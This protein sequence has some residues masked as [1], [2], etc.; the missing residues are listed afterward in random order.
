MTATTELRRWWDSLL[1]EPQ[2][3]EPGQKLAAW[4][5]TIAVAVT[6]L[7]ARSK[8]AW[9]W[10]EGLF[11]SALRHYDVRA[12]HPHPPGFPLFIATGKLFTFLGLSEFHA[13]Q[14]ISLLAS[15]AIVPA[16]LMLGRE[17]RAGF[18]PTLIAGVFLAFFPNVWFF[19]GTAFS[20]VPS[21]TIVIVA[22][23]LLLRGCRSD[24]A[25]YGGAIMLGIAAGYRPQNLLIGFAPSMVVVIRAL[26]RRWLQVVI[27]AA[28]GAAIIAVSYGLAAH[29]SG[30]WTSYS[31]VLHA[32]QRYIATVDSYQSPD[33]PPLS[34]MFDKF[35]IRPYRLPAANVFV[36]LL[37]T[38]GAVVA[39]VRVRIPA[40]LML[41]SF[42][43][44]C[45]VAWLV[46]DRF[47]VSR[48]SIG[49]APLMALLAAE[50]LHALA[51][52]TPR[53]EAAVAFLFAAA[54]TVWIWPALREVRRHPSPPAVAAEWIRKHVDPA[55]STLYVHISM[56]PL[57]EGLLPGFPYVSTG[58][59]TPVLTAAK[60]DNDVFVIEAAS[61]A[62]GA[63]VL[64]R[65]HERLADL[66]RDRYFEVSILPLQQIITFLDGWYAEER[67]GDLTWRWMGQRAR[68]LLPPLTG[69]GQLRVAF[70]VPLDVLGVPPTIQ[71][72][73]NGTVV[74]RVRAVTAEI[75]RTVIVPSRTDAPNELV[76][77]TDRTVNPAA[78]GVGADTRNLGL[79]LGGIEWSRAGGAR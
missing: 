58:E 40:L 3:L 43:P 69:N 27:A 56:R 20:D 68:C 6:R 67:S 57:I 38:I 21:M 4:L 51:G 37:V 17:L 52:R 32:H 13:L 70:Y 30:G 53:I 65:P 7:F 10:D 71:L 63:F 50:G 11:M 74:D 77:E 64:R 61:P 23:A 41:A 19:G 29:L 60:R 66:V 25:L 2:P 62:K 5:V 78:R 16:M 12:H 34:Q 15:I 54:I 26:P 55:T 73:L 44:F 35:F 79:R 49:Y 28:A 33:R 46:L 14:T 76:F 47:S 39:V 59:L 1:E 24:A 18:R 22:M 36:T 8:T 45:I 31:E 48:F 72:R 42:G 9:D 75:E